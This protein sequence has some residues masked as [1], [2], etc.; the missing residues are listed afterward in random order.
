MKGTVSKYETS[1]GARW[2]ITYDVGVDPVSGKRRQTTKRGFKRERDADAELR[3]LL[4]SVEDGTHVGF[5]RLTVAGYLSEWLERRKPVPGRSARGH[6]GKVGIGT[7]GAYKQS[8]DAYVVP[9][10]GAH[11]LQHLSPADIERLYDDLEA[12]GGR[13]GK[14]LS[15]TTIS[16]LH[17]VLHKALS[18]AVREGKLSTNPAA[19]VD[20]PK[21]DRQRTEVWS[22]EQL[23]AFLG[24]VDD[25]RLRAMW[26]LFATTGMRRGEV[27]G[28]T[29]NNI[30]LDAGTVRIDWTLGVV[31]AKPTWKP[32]PKSEAGERTMALDPDTVAALREH[33]RRQLEERMLAGAGW[34]S[35]ATDWQGVTRSDLVFTWPDGR[36]INPER[37]SKWF[38]TAATG[39]GLPIIRLHDVRHTYAT[40]GLA[41]ATGWHEVKV[42]SQRLGHASVGITLDTY[43]HVLPAADE[44]TAHTLAKLIMGGTA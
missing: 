6:R 33:R 25:D 27:A 24:H 9:R 20:P 38:N 31:N 11:R 16:N 13:G 40:A 19:R 34:Q 37:I 21:A 35:D 5:D 12:G 41:N 14:P 18:D 2:R 28:L 1:S 26:L 10:I 36:L 32:R 15:A 3:R 7:W 8:I 39:A 44:Q 42:I 43:S 4:G 17:A 29:W 30:D 23:R 22:V